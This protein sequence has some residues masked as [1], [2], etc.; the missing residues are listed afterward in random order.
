MTTEDSDEK[1]MREALAA[2]RSSRPSP[3]PPVGAVVVSAGGEAVARAWHAEAGA[4]HAEIAALEEAAEAAEG[5]SLYVTLEPCNHEGQTGRCVDAILRAG[6]KRVVVGALDPNP[7]VEGGGAERLKNAG[8]DVVVGVAGAESQTLIAPWTKFITS[9]VP[10]VALKLA[11]S[12][13]G[14]IA[15]R[16]GESKWITCPEARVKVQQLRSQYDAV[17]VGI[18]TALSDDPRLTVRDE[19]LLG[20]RPGP[21]RIIFDT[22]LRLPASSRVVATANEL[23]TWICAGTEA[24]EEN[25]QELVAAGCKVMRVPMSAQGRVDMAA[26]LEAIGE[27]GIVSVLVEGGAELVG[28]LVAGRHADELHA[29]LAPK[30]LGPRGRPGAVDWAGPDKPG[31]APHILN[32]RWEVC[33]QD[34]YVYGK[35]AYPE[36]TAG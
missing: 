5:G 10:H 22:S 33:G 14:R 28:S 1:W 4:Q 24:D 19:S 11:L 6:I 32:P 34:A 35:V 16:T 9:A 12:L 8:L 25:E 7:H 26:A 3:N 20:S 23:P 27:A 18:G 15:T 29:F 31:E 21:V 17:A 30:L 2:A 36:K 13:D